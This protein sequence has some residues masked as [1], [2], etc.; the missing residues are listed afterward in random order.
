MDSFGANLMKF[1][2]QLSLSL[3]LLI[4][5]TLFAATYVVS[6]SEDSTSM[7]PS[8]SLR[9]AMLN[10]FFDNDSSFTITFEDNLGMIHLVDHLPVLSS[11]QSSSV[12]FTVDGGIG[13][14]ID[15]NGLYQAFFVTPTNNNGI[16]ATG[17][18][19][20]TISNLTF[21]NC[22]VKG[23]DGVDGG[24]GAMGAGGAI[25]VDNNASVSG[26]SL[27]F[28]NC[29]AIGGN[30]QINSSTKSGGGGGGA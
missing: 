23:G 16:S 5:T 9:E 29:S 2:K 1:Q 30:S 18:I 10:A 22:S 11:Y 7:V 25:F 6:T 24:G 17:S 14:G 27:T 12:I 3:I 15:G 13:N 26:H 28:N 20:A 21:S 8:G 4:Q 19:A